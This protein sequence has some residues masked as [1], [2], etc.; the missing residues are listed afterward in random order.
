MELMEKFRGSEET[1][2]KIFSISI[3]NDLLNSAY[4]YLL[5]LFIEIESNV[6]NKLLYQN[7]LTSKIECLSARGYTPITSEVLD[8]NIR[9]SISHGG[10][11]FNRNKIIFKYKIGSKYMSK[12][13]SIYEF[14]I[15][16]KEMFDIISSI[17]LSIFLYLYKSNVNMNLF[18]DNNKDSDCHEFIRKIQIS[19][20]SIKCNYIY[21]F[22][23]MGNQEIIQCNVELFHSDID[24]KSRYDFALGS[25]LEIVEMMNLGEKDYLF[26]SFKSKHSM[27]SFFKINVRLLLDTYFENIPYE[28]VI[29]IL[30]KD[31]LMWKVNDEERNDIEDLFRFYEN[32]ETE[33][34]KITEISDISLEGY[35]RFK[36]NIYFKEDIKKFY[37]KKF[38][39]E[40]VENI[41]ILKNYGFSN[42]RVKHGD[43]EADVIHMSAYKKDLRR[44]EK[45]S[46]RPENDNFICI[47]QY[48]TNKKFS[49]KN[50][51][52]DSKLSPER[53]ENI[54]YRWNPNFR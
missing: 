11:S 8:T 2:A 33:S 5:E 19:T 17:C 26:F 27:D 48:D 12:E 41:K 40:A 44:G 10:E 21:N 31:N 15:K 20:T 45:R 22:H 47:A 14:T 36:C 46:W 49:I 13:Q 30:E 39:E 3:Y 53:K 50:N 23:P 1:K 4:S 32:I 18:F 35:K 9:N 28:E 42:N 54:E 52:V 24:A 16:L 29:N 37:V 25:G 6:E 34:F 43:M 7:S 51:L 38:V